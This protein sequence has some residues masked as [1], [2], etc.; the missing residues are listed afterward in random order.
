MNV[1]VSGD[2]GCC[3]AQRLSDES[4]LFAVATGFGRIDGEPVA[5]FALT[6][7]RQRI[8]RA[9]K[10]RSVAAMLGN[11]VARVNDELHARSASHEDYVTAGASMTAVLLLRER[12]YLAHVGSTAAYL[13]RGG[14]VVALTKNDAFEDGFG[15]PVLIRAL[16]LTRTLDM[17]VSAFALAPG[18]ALVLAEHE[19]PA[20]AERLVVTFNGSREAEVPAPAGAHLAQSILTGVLATALFYAMLSIR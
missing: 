6:H 9:P 5:S 3:L 7:L 14:S 12:A 18:D 17:T 4:Y 10:P 2:R 19:L 11:V 15:R 1:A 8:Q 13:A 16:G 20:R